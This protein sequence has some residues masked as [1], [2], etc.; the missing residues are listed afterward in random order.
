MGVSLAVDLRM[1]L[2]Q[3]PFGDRS[4]N[5]VSHHTEARGG[6]S[7][8]LTRAILPRFILLLSRKLLCSV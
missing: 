4:M 2:A 5:A 8:E 3:V 1:V 6:K 7:R